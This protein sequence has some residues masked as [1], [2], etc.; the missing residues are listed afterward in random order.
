MTP[1]LGQEIS[2]NLEAW[3]NWLES[4]EPHNE[5]LPE[6]YLEIDY[7]HKLLLLKAFR[8][9]KLNFGIINF[10]EQKLGSHY[11]SVPPVIMNEA[12]EDTKNRAPIIFILST[13]AD[14]NSLMRAF[15]LER[16]YIE[17]LDIVSLGQ[18]QDVRAKK[19]IESGCKTGN[20]VM[21]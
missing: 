16:N 4:K 2:D 9:E 13:G 11:V 12:Y 14:P 18:G 1:L 3:R 6:R 20:W 21:L 8:D 5:P 19:F 7:F 15:A 10:I 17:K